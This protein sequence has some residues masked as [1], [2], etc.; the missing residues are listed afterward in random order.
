MRH[1]ST[2]LR[3]NRSSVI[4]DTSSTTTGRVR[5]RHPQLP[6]L[7]YSV[8]N[9]SWRVV[10]RR[11]RTHPHEVVAVEDISGNTPLH[12]ACRLDP[13][14]D[15]IYALKRAVWDRN[16]EGATAL[17]IAAS[18]RC[19]VQVIQALIG[20]S[21]EYDDHERTPST[22]VASPK[23]SFSFHS[24]WTSSG[25]T[26]RTHPTGAFEEHAQSSSTTATQPSPTTVIQQR[27][28]MTLT[29]TKM[30]RSP[31]HYACL[32]YR[33]L[34][35]EAFSFLLEATIEACKQSHQ[36]EGVQLLNDTTSTVSEKE[37]LSKLNHQEHE[38]MKG[39]TDTVK[40][41][42]LHAPSVL[43]LSAFTMI[44]QAGQTPLA[45]LF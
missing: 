29:R 3:R 36:D 32:S 41:T 15:V 31:L 21:S 24:Y 35:V 27:S 11:S 5:F 45:L 28:H 30:G 43:K 17:H 38:S 4:H 13:P 33:G 9:R 1:L 2:D 34:G 6:P 40:N 20:L 42:V 39:T 37:T 18:H 7:F 22:S 8:L 26:K 25:S 10:I 12:F 23:F 14:I 44:D 16:N 19:S